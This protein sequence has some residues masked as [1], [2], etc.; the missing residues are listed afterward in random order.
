MEDIHDSQTKSDNECCKHEVV[1]RRYKTDVLDTTIQPGFESVVAFEY[2]QCADITCLRDTA[3]HDKES[4]TP[5]TTKNIGCR[6]PLCE[7]MYNILRTE[8]TG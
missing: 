7:E 6:E 2:A 3:M 1:I 4:N 5:V 8:K